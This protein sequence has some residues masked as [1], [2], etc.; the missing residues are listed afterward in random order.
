MPHDAWP[1]SR[2]Q[3]AGAPGHGH[4][5]PAAVPPL[6]ATGKL[7][8]TVTHAVRSAHGAVL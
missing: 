2:P 6:C 8:D 3:Q 1:G 4:F 7:A 5:R